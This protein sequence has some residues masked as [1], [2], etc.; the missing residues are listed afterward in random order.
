MNFASRISVLFLAIAGTWGAAQVPPS[1]ANH[2]V[3]GIVVS[4]K[5]GE[6]LKDATVIL[7]ES[8]HRKV[9][10]ETSADSAGRFRFS[11]IPEGKYDL[12]AS[13]TG[14]VPSAYQQHDGG[15]NTAI[16][17]GDGLVSTGLLFEL[18]PQAR[19][20]GTVQEDSGDPVPSAEVKL[21][22]RDIFRGTGRM[23]LVRGDNADPMGNFELTGLS[24]DKYV[25]C[26][27]GT[28]WYYKPRQSFPG[29]QLPA[30]PNGFA[31]L[32]VV[33]APTCYPDAT[34]PAEAE[35]IT[36]S[37]GEQLPLNITLHPVPAVHLS[38][39]M[40]P[41]DGHGFSPPQVSTD[42]FGTPQF[43]RSQ[44]NF[45][46]QEPGKPQTAEIDVPAGQ[47]TL[48]FPGENGEPARHMSI[49]TDAGAA[50]VNPSATDPDA[51]CTGTVISENGEVLP[52]NSFLL[53]E[54]T[55]GE[56]GGNAQL[57]PDG[58][59]TVQSLKPG[60]YRII[61]VSN[62]AL[63]GIAHLSA[64]GAQ[65]RGHSLTIGSE[66][67]QVN[68]I[69]RQSNATVNG[70]VKRNGAPA[71]GVFV[72]LIPTGLQQMG[73]R[74]FPNQSDSDGTFNF[75]RVPAGDYTVV[76]IENGWKL[77]WANPEV[78]KPYLARGQHLRV[79]PA[80]R[81]INL[82]DPLQPLAQNLK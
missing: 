8:S 78:I 56:T 51:Q 22:Q 19:I 40:P 72:L 5:S 54:P 57:S 44:I 65:V 9:V 24:P 12:V 60:A 3:S 26:V 45:G 48:S 61:A 32:N 73:D 80:M 46:P 68:L 71:S 47:Y 69:V 23:G 58:T 59:F 30:D 2:E 11:G 39:V 29:T 38:V 49:N 41:N 82:Q 64:R 28:P 14:Y 75:R 50:N 81:D 42:L 79:A 53:F 25:V 77:D 31:R 70:I 36:I 43:V 35:P 27:I 13:R 6:P 67:V 1:Y 4:A 34:D 76:A 18:Q 62:G 66:P 33:Y 55:D 63:L 17:T 7:I 20:Y 52:K 10:A 15:I 21:F 16:V 74:P 37:P